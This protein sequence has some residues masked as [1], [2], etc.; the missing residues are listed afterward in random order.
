MDFADQIKQFSKRIETLKTTIKTEEA[1]K[2][3]LILP[4]FTMLGYDVFNPFEFVPEFV[5]DVGTK[6]GEKVDYA[7]MQD[8]EPIIIVEAKACN[9][10]LNSKHINQLFRYFSVTNARFCI[11]TNGIIYRFYSDIDET[12][13][14][15]LIPFLEINLLHLTEKNINELK[16][17]HKSEF[18][19]KNILSNA[20]ELKYSALMKNA[21]SEQINNPSDQFIKSIIKDIY[22]G[23][24]TQTVIEKF[25]PII[26]D[27]FNVYINDI[28]EEKLKNI[29][30]SP[31]NEIAITVQDS[32]PEKVVERNFSDRELYMLNYIKNNI[33]ND[34]DDI[35]FKKTDNYI[36]IQLG[37]NNRKWICR[38]FIR[39]SNTHL[40]VL[41]KFGDY[42][43][44]Y[45]FD[46][47]S[48]LLQ[49]S[50]LIQEVSNHCL[51]GT[52]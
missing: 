39:S 7:I 35:T 13:K 10:E 28:L 44:E 33:L 24:K 23:I 1:T 52:N 36:A 2:T 5:A 11:L 25:R 6:K 29:I 42:E 30:N 15:D 46:E 14:M 47:V 32:V 51:K 18:D 26:K 16:H 3:S 48:Q 9:S 20:A 17:F 4:F 49:I 41:H 22:A 27:A 43:C 21:L 45:T 19:I 34:I 38:I 31:N 50:E 40:F 37:N 12:N 8:N